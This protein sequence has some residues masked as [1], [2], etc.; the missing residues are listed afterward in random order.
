MTKVQLV[1]PVYNEQQILPESVS[2]LRGWCLDHPEYDWQITIANNASTDDT[3]AVA[4][5]LALTYEDLVTVHDIGVK[6][7][8]IALKTVW[9]TSEADIV[10]YMDIDLS[11]DINHITE[12]IEP[13][14]SGDSEISYGSRLHKDAKTKRSFKR[15]FISRSY[16]LVLRLLAGLKVTDAQCGFKAMSNSAATRLL[17]EVIDTQWFFDSELLII[18][19]H[20]GIAM[21]EVPV[22]WDED[23]DTRVKII[24]TALEDLS[25]IWRLRRNGIPIVAPAGQESL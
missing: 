22:R 7:R 21:K 3:L 11:T 4:R 16:V 18:A 8:G 5:K 25:G 23:T 6:G 1:L 14:V 2:K 12:L 15:E 9:L 24:Q 19:Q 13:I 20:N 17:P 10:A